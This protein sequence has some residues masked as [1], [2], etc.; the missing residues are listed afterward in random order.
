MNT[1]IEIM[2]EFEI[3]HLK[4]DFA[5]NYIC[6]SIEYIWK[7]LQNTD[8]YAKVSVIQMILQMG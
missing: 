4:H 7:L 2:D 8:G 3:F 5:E 6:L 1:S